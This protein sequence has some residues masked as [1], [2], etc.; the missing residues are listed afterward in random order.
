[1]TLR[2][3][4]HRPPVRHGFLDLP[5]FTW[6]SASEAS[7]LTDGG[8]WLIRRYRVPRE[9]ANVVAD[10]AGIGPEHKR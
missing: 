2:R 5:L 10:L 1:M 4:H 6:A 9:L 3:I 7:P 8:R